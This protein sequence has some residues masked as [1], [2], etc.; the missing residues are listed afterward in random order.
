[1]RRVGT[2]SKCFLGFQKEA[3][4]RTVRRSSPVVLE[5]VSFCEIWRAALGSQA[6]C[7]G[8]ET[9]R[10]GVHIVW[11][12]APL[13]HMLRQVTVCVLS[14]LHLI[15]LSGAQP[16][17][18][19][20]ESKIKNG[21]SCKSRLKRRKVVSD[22]LHCFRECASSHRSW[23]SF[24]RSIVPHKLREQRALLLLEGSKGQQRDQEAAGGPVGD[25]LVSELLHRRDCAYVGAGGPV[26]AKIVLTPSRV[27]PLAHLDT[28]DSICSDIFI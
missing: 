16:C 24:V 9:L 20:F 27:A 7:K 5:G 2:T 11:R 13:Q 15:A 23:G 12:G 25:G 10:C 17:C 3:G 1:M 6:A 8:A 26:S 21:D 18:Y 19:L 4:V 28:L 14:Y 22:A